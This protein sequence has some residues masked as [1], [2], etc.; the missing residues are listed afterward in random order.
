MNITRK[1]NNS[2]ASFEQMF[3]DLMN[4]KVDEFITTKYL[5]KKDS[6]EKGELHHV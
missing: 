6:R 3:N 1:F 4:A 2:G 5:K